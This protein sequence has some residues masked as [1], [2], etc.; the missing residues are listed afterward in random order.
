MESRIQRT[1][2]QWFP[3]AF[4]DDNISTLRTDYDFLNHFAEYVKAL[5]NNNCENKKEPLN[6]INL[7]YSKGTLFERNAIEN[8]F[9]FV[10]A[11]DEKSQ[12]LK[13]NLSIMPEALKAVYIKTILEN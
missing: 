5:I 2:T 3:D 8:A 4:T 10:L 11:S 12:T 1:L 13:E 7:L 9:L 6:I